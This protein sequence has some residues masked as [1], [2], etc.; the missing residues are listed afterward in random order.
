M[1][2][3]QQ[4]PCPPGLEQ[5]LRAAK[6]ELEAII[7]NVGDALVVQALT[8]V[9]T[10]A[11][12]AAA[13]L[14][15]FPSPEALRAAPASALLSGIQPL[16][17][18]GNRIPVERLPSRVALA[19]RRPARATLR[20]VSTATKEE[21]FADVSATPVANESGVVCCVVTLFHDVTEQR[22]AEEK[23]RQLYEAERESRA[24]ADAARRRFEFLAEASDVLGSSLDYSA[25]LAAVTRLAVPRIADW[26]IVELAG[27]RPFGGEHMVV[28]HT[29]PAK[30]E[31]AREATYR[32]PRDPHAPRGVPAV[33]RS[34]RSELYK[35]ITDEMLAEAARDE[36]HLGFLRSAQVRSLMIVA[37]KARDVIVGTIVFITAE[38]G[39][40]YDEGD[41]AMAEQLARRAAVSV[42]NARLYRE[43]TDAIHARDRFLSMAGHDLRTP[44]TVLHLQLESVLRDI[45]RGEPVAKSREKLS[46]ALL[47]SS[48]LGR[49]VDELLDVS[50][51][52]GGRIELMPRE[53]SLAD[54]VYDAVGRLEE[55][56]ARSGSEL[57]IQVHGDT[58]G[59]WD[60][61]RLTEVV[62]N[63]VENAIKYG[64]GKPI[65]VGLQG[66]EDEVTLTV[67]DQGIGIAP[68]DQERIFQRFEQVV[69]EPE[70]G[71]LGLGLWIVRNLVEGHGGRVSVQSHPRKGATFTVTL[72]RGPFAEGGGR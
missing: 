43:A 64:R 50:G 23:I 56:L 40:R 19:T 27:E 71:G 65:E 44:H 16:D 72:P 36:E 62:L 29:D 30:V 45:E 13:D 15:G 20:L 52:S 38:S 42:E 5:E 57:H 28:A 61:L 46:R 49:I 11:N 7:R 14:L 54:L 2:P 37:M 48:R 34:G 55:P 68:A 12:Q 53:V 26:C 3:E 1:R 63:L 8:G 4:S 59:E 66:R 39:R 58:R 9:V 47:A 32:L 33:L 21:R 17:E 60:P 41:L 18:H 31:P 67:R 24:E 70:G 35:D 22:R 51:L 25:T 69:P 10:H 6:D